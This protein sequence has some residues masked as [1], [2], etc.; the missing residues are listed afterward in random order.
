MAAPRSPELGPKR[1][2]WRTATRRPTGGSTATAR[3]FSPQVGRNYLFHNSRAFLAISREKNDTR[4][5]KTLGLNDYYFG[6]TDFEYPMGNL[7]MVGKSSAPM[8]RG[9]KP[10]EYV[11]GPNVRP[12]RRGRARGRLLAVGGDLP[13][14][15]N[16]VTL[17]RDGNVVLAY[18][19]NNAEPME[20]LYRSVKKHLSVWACIRTT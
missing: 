17:D 4:F 19:L 5:Q 18:T 11:L 7:Q 8:Y 6:D 16:W 2:S 9:E 10:I 15:D 13:D 3:R 14:P 12:A 1:C 20:Q